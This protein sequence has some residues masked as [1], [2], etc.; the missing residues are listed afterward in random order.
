MMRIWWEGA[1]KGMNLKDLE[2][3][4]LPNGT[5]WVQGAAWRSWTEVEPIPG[6]DL[7]GLSSV[8]EWTACHA[9]ETSGW[10]PGGWA[11]DLCSGEG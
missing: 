4:E 1:G 7:T 2:E 8:W 5:D 6:M 3:T 11:E 10:S 9:Y